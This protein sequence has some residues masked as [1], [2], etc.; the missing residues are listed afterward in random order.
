MLAYKES[1]GGVTYIELTNIVQNSFIT[2]YGIIT[3]TY[4][5]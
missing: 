1:I 3:I 4:Y 2:F 5:S